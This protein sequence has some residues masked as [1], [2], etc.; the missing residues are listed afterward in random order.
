MNPAR[1]VLI[2]ATLL[3]SLL[4]IGAVRAG[5][6]ETLEQ[7]ARQ[8]TSDD[9]VAR[10][11]AVQALRAAGPAG[12]AVLCRENA[13][14]IAK[15]P[16]ARGGPDT[17]DNPA[18]VWSR[19]AYALD[20]VGMARDTYSSRLFWYTDLDQAR[21]AAQAAHKPILSLRLLGNLDDEYSCANS[22]YFRTVLY[23]NTSL[24]SYL[25]DNYILH[26]QSVRTAPRITIDF[27]DGRRLE[28]TITGNSIHYVLDSDGNVVDALPGLYGPQ[29]FLR[30]LRE[31]APAARGQTTPDARVAYAQ[32]ATRELGSAWAHDLDVL[33]IAL[34]AS[35]KK[36]ADAANRAPAAVDAAPIAMSKLGSERVLLRQLFPAAQVQALTDAA[37]WT[38]LAAL[39]RKD[40]ELDQASLRFMCDKSPLLRSLSAEPSD[41]PMVSAFTDSVALDT[42]RNEYLLRRTICE[43]LAAEG[44]RARLDA[45]NQRVYSELFLTPD[46]DPWLGLLPRDTYTALENDGVVNGPAA[47]R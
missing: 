7:L 13:A 21:A 26:W 37:G 46:S 10:A 17:A 34:P 2:A 12:L 42:V 32:R 43:W 28:R 39:H 25:R 23:A 30:R 31:A 35:I 14:I 40:A 11:H 41:T 45:L 3:A 33:G 18:A 24:G 44:G 4:T 19:L 5:C 47:R 1:L 38:R 27:G 6:P 9:A 36:L 8:A 20:Q 29:A 15:G 22:R 16:Q